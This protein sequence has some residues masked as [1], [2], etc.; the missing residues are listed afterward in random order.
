MKKITITLVALIGTITMYAANPLKLTGGNTSV[1]RQEATANVIIDDHKA[2]IDRTGKTADVYYGEQSDRK[3]AAFTSDLDRGH[4]SFR[5]YFNDKQPGTIKMKLAE[6]REN[7]EYTLHIT[8]RLI[9]IGH[10]GVLPKN[11]GVAISGT[12]ELVDNATGETVCTFEFENV[13]GFMAPKF[14]DRVISTYR[15]LADYLIKTI[16]PDAT[17]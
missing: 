3:Y 10:F 7:T 4:L 12:M 15:Y 8:V 6:S 2:T 5:T 14:R 11:G 16:S 13:K 1:F 17:I 9:N